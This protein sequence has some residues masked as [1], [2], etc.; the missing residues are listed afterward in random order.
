M[1]PCRR[2][3]CWRSAIR[4]FGRGCTR[5]AADR[6]ASRVRL[7]SASGGAVANASAEVLQPGPRGRRR[8]AAGRGRAPD[9]AASGGQLLAEPGVL[10]AQP[11]DPTPVV[12]ELA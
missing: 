10:G 6:A 4:A 7:T 3:A 12:V 9:L 8:P 2:T 1:S 11:V 5:C